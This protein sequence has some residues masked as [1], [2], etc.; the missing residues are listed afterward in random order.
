MKPIRIDDSDLKKIFRKETP[1]TRFLR[2]LG[3]IVR[4]LIYLALIF[5]FFFVAINYG[6]FYQQIHYFFENKSSAPVD[7]VVA[8]PPVATPT[9]PKPNYAPELSIP[10]IGI[11][12]P[13]VMD[14][15]I[16]QVH[17]HL[18]EGVV[19]VQGSA[20]P[21][22]IGNV[23][24]FGHSSDYP[25]SPGNYR[26]IFAL[27]D[28]VTTGD[29]IAFYFKDQEFIYQITSTHVVAPTDLDVIQKS[30][31]PTLTLVTC[32]PVGT[33]SKRLVVDATLVSGITTGTQTSS[34]ITTSLPSPR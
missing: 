34:P 9:A 25:W 29:Q 7:I 21:G 5:V 1:V 18:E 17:A 24:I 27:L 15:P 12:A 16:D 6:A 13:V 10:K 3:L 20:E 8:Q 22:Q 2:T 32:Y 30:D 4:Q 28:N 19:H 14:V 26:N 31:T 23:V 33:A 11:S